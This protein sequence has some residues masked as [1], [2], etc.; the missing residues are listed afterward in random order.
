MDNAVRKSDVAENCLHVTSEIGRLR[1]VLLHRPGQEVENLTPDLLERL[2]FDDIP[3]LEVAR[4]EHDI[5]AQVL[6][7]NGVEVLY[8]EKLAA[9]ALTDAH[10]KGAFIS[11]FIAE[12]AVENENLKYALTDYFYGF[13]NQEMIDKMMAGVRREELALYQG[14]SLYDRVNGLYP[15]LCDP[16]PNLYFTRDPFATIGN[17]I[18]LNRRSDRD[19][20]VASNLSHSKSRLHGGDSFRCTKKSFRKFA[21][22]FLYLASREN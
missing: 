4:K 8:L 17:G 11:Q 18:T 1:S 22:G 12:A 19:G 20:S 7:N 3:Y 9:E 14:S 15:F 10:I 5:F 16:M 21:E 13:S 6:K 2:L